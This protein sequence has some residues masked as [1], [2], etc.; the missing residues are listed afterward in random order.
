MV[1]APLDASLRPRAAQLVA[2]GISAKDAAA[3]LGINA[4]TLR[5]WLSRDRA[6][7]VRQSSRTNG[8]TPA[9]LNGQT[10]RRL[11]ITATQT[12]SRPAPSRAR[13]TLT[14]AVESLAD[15]AKAC[16]DLDLACSSVDRLARAGKNLEL[17][18]GANSIVETS[19]AMLYEQAAQPVPERPAIDVESKPSGSG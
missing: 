4:A 19:V 6:K 18:S 7:A 2:S 11:Q 3:Q 8:T 13:D 10:S 15:R 14:A 5:K 1:A 12:V 16:E 9:A 17:W